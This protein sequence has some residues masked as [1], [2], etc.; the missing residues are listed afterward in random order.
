MDDP[1]SRQVAGQ[2]LG[3][4]AMVILLFPV[5]DFLQNRQQPAFAFRHQS[6]PA[7]SHREQLTI[8]I[9]PDVPWGQVKAANCIKHNIVV[10]DDFSNRS[11][12]FRQ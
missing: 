11:L 9:Q 4:L 5:L 6:H 3:Q 2:G 1:V 7:A 12:A 8:L 10:P